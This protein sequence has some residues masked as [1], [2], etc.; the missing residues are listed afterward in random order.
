LKII[1]NEEVGVLYPRCV[2]VT[3]EA[4][5]QHDAGPK[6]VPVPEDFIEEEVL[7][8]ESGESESDEADPED[9]VEKISLDELTPGEPD[10]EEEPREGD[11]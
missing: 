2:K 1:I 11:D 8:E 9:G 10:V 7:V 5:K 3:G 4:P 6:V